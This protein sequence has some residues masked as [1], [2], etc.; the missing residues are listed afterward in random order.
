M[1]DMF[2]GDGPRALCLMFL[3]IAHSALHIYILS[4]RDSGTDSK[5]SRGTNFQ[6]AGVLPLKN[7]IKIATF[8]AIHNFLIFRDERPASP[9]SQW[10]SQ[11]MTTF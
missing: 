9:I 8:R 5:K 2:R 6:I 10:F 3:Q 1:A 11:G 4:D 7:A